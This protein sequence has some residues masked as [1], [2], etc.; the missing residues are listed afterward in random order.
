[1]EENT[2]KKEDTRGPVI[3]LVEFLV[4][5]LFKLFSSDGIHM[6]SFNVP[7]QFINMSVFKRF[8]GETKKFS[9]NLSNVC[10]QLPA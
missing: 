5:I 7:E 3:K 4:Q 10:K 9:S 6:V 1:L 8:L 2:N